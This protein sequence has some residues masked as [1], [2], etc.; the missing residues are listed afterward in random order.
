M[1]ALGLSTSELGGSGDGKTE[2][3]DDLDG[4]IGQWR[5]EK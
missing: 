3:I 5:G 2:K 1:N 4:E